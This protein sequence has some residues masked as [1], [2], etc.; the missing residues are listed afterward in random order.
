MGAS[1]NTRTVVVTGGANGIGEATSMLFASH[2]YN[3]VVVDVDIK[4]GMEVVGNIINNTAS[5][6]CFVRADVSLADECQAVIDKTLDQFGRI[7]V[8]FNNAGITRRASVIETSVEEWDRVLAVNCRSVFLMCKFTIPIM[9]QQKGG[10]IVNT[11]SGWG[12]VGGAKAFSYCASK[13]AIVLMTKAMALDYGDNNVRVNCICPG[14]TDT[15]LL[16]DEAMQLDLP[17]DTLVKS[18]VNRPLKRV[19]RPE[20]IAQGVYFLASDAASFITGESLVID[21]GG[22]AG[23]Q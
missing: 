11:A 16:R 9:I 4:K 8:L 1:S 10:S 3:V 17:E 5:Q 7:D 6:G 23:S 19:G 20:E 15:N 18:G 14:D 2:G 12:L 22:L 21:G 13:G